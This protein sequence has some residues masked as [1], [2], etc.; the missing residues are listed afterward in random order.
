MRRYLVLLLA[1]VELSF[2]QSIA[3]AHTDGGSRSMIRSV[4][5]DDGLPSNGV[6]CIV[7]DKQGYIWFGSD[8][9]LCRYDGY[10][11]QK[12]YNPNLIKPVCL[13]SCCL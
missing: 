6:R 5:M 12:Y 4:T 3:V 2:G 10:G 1:A 9:G 11:V 13:C 8:N 7:Q